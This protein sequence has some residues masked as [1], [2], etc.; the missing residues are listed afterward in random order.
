L[1]RIKLIFCTD[2]IFPNSVGG[3]QRHSRLLIEQLA[4]SNR[5][6]LVV[7]HPHKEKIFKE[8]L[9]VHEIS[10]QEINVN[11]NYLLECYRYSKRVY[12]A[13]RKY[14]QHLIYSQGLSV[15]YNIKNIQ[16]RLLVNPHGLEPYQVITLKEK[17]ISIPFKIIFKYIF[18]HS[19]V[20]ISLG[21]TLT[22]ILKTQLKNNDTEV[23]TIPNGVNASDYNHKEKKFNLLRLN[24]LFVARFAHNKGIHILL[25]AIKELNEEGWEDKL[26]FNLGGKGPLF[27]HYR[28]KCNYK[29]VNYLG[30]ILD[31]QLI[32]LY[33]KADV[34]VFPTLFEGMPTVVLEAMSFGLPVIVSN[35]GATAE[36]VDGENGYLIAENSVSQLKA[37]IIDFYH[38]DDAS[39]AQLSNASFK[40]VAE[41]YTWPLIAK[42][43]IRLFE[44]RMLENK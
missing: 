22:S 8:A 6:D 20:V 43:Y 25:Q 14:P 15:W 32:D 4:M 44:K 31:E 9:S 13:I 37:A 39:K 36:L 18:D 16:Q 21:G 17:L 24:L 12:A 41:R 40:K 3:M 26:V 7:I 27:E 2:G 33:K 5:F 23:V 42:Q 34:F 1:D 28:N 35:V 11:K 38:R 30:F 29:N 10:I 19:A